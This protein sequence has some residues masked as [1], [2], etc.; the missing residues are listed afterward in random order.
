MSNQKILFYWAHRFFSLFAM[1]RKKFNLTRKQAEFN[2]SRPMGH[3]FELK[4]FLNLFH[5]LSGHRFRSFFETSTVFRLF[6]TRLRVK[7]TVANAN[8]NQSDLISIWVMLFAWNHRAR[9]WSYSKFDCFFVFIFIA[10]H[11]SC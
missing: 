7:Y 9:F 6:V 2:W 10:A 5:V 11:F 4:I 1:Q 8:G 3:L